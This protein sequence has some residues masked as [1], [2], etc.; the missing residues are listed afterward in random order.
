MVKTE[1]ETQ[2]DYEIIDL[3]SD[4]NYPSFSG[5]ESDP[6]SIVNDNVL[7]SPKR[8]IVTNNDSVDVVEESS[9][10]RPVT[11]EG[12]SDELPAFQDNDFVP[13]RWSSRHNKGIPPTRYSP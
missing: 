4:D 8:E 12:E 2:I 1:P 5:D 3:T 6:H 9:F 11:P 7:Q 10:S 13:I